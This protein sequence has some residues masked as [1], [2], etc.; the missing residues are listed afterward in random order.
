MPQFILTTPECHVLQQKQRKSDLI[1]KT[2]A[3]IQHAIDIE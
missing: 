2:L 3:A 1:N